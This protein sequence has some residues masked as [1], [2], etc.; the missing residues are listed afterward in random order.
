M[1]N[2]STR[3]ML[4]LYHH[5]IPQSNAYKYCTLQIARLWFLFFKI[6]KERYTRRA[7]LK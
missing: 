3:D 7:T 4:R 2:F 5:N 1:C 6:A